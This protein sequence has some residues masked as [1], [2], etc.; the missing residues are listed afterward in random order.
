[1]VT[2]QLPVFGIRVACDP[3]TG[4]GTI[5]SALHGEDDGPELTAALDAIE[6]LVLAHACAGVAVDAPAYVE[7]LQTA[8]DK[9]A[10]AFD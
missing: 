5:A 2:F 3:T 7:G 1:M 8:L 10:Q 4:A 6:S 9:L